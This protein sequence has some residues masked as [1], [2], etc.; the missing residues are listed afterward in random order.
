[1]KQTLLYMVLAAGLASTAAGAATRPATAPAPATAA[2]ELA[3]LRGGTGEAPVS[4]TPEALAAL[5]QRVLV[6]CGLADQTV[7]KLPWY[8]HFEFGRQLLDAGD[9]RRAA[10]HLVHA[11]QL[12]P[13]P[14]DDKRMY[15]QWYVA[16]LPYAE[17]ATA[18]ARLGNWP[19]AADALALARAYDEPKKANFDHARYDEV[20]AAV[21]SHA[22]DPTS[23]RKQDIVEPGYDADVN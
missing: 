21:A 10:A 15:G 3:A 11:V 9:A 2:G 8:F 16:Y 4:L 23:C 14:S 6:Q 18:Q 5:R 17:L 19:C 22:G 13:Q 12:N 7:D 1:M 20:S